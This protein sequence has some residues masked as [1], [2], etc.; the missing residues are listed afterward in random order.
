MDSMRVLF[1][2]E[3][4]FLINAFSN[5]KCWVS[6]WFASSVCFPKEIRCTA[7][8]SQLTKVEWKSWNRIWTRFSLSAIVIHSF[9]NSCESSKISFVFFP[10]T[11]SLRKI[12][13]LRLLYHRCHF[14]FCRFSVEPFFLL[15]QSI[16]VRNSGPFSVFFPFFLQL[17]LEFRQ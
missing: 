1:L 11:F 2:F 10:E 6:L 5:S 3:V 12:D 7:P 13:W 16:S 15:F 17:F 4:G 14:D 9:W 8:F